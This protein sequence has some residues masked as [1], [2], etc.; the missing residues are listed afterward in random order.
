MP[1]KIILFIILSFA[2]TLAQAAT[3][4]L[5]GSHD[6]KINQLTL[7][8]NEQLWLAKKENINVG[9]YAPL[10]PPLSIISTNNEI[11]G[12]DADYLTLLKNTL[13]INLIIN[14]FKD[15]K[16]AYSALSSGEVDLVID[17]SQSKYA[18]NNSVIVSKPF[19]YSYPA[20][21]TQ[22][23]K[24]MKYPDQDEKTYVAIANNYPGEK[25]I[26]SIYKNAIIK[27]HNSAEEALLSIANGTADVFIGDKL[28]ADYYLSNEFH[29]ELNQ[30]KVWRSEEITQSIVV[31]KNNPVLAEIINIRP[32]SSD[33]AGNTTVVYVLDIGGHLLKGTEKN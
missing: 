17:K 31:N 33:G 1:K 4:K 8:D 19:I 9:V 11:S 7:N 3:L 2:N 16:Q 30:V 12:A 26:R 10:M 5:A 24:M 25:F 23:D 22:R 29:H 14:S 27:R 32:V 15:A 6:Y 28:E 20:L 21:I 13:N 18:P